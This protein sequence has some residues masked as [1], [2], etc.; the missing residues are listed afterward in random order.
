MVPITAIL[1]GLGIAL[2]ALK[3]RAKRNQMEHEERML[4]IEKGVALPPAMIPPA[5][6]KNPYLWGF[7]LIAVGSAVAIGM[8]MEGDPD[9]AWGG[10]FLLPGVALLLANW[11]YVRDKKG[12][13]ADT[14]ESL[15]KGMDSPPDESK[16]G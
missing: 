11:F 16:V 3:H 15:P 7:I 4:A 12:K 14:Q 2:A 13:E 8:A 1:V 9:W 6:T 10:I 5:R